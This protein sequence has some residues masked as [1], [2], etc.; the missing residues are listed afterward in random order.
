MLESVLCATR[1]EE[2]KRR[3]ELSVF[4]HIGEEYDQPGSILEDN[5]EHGL[6]R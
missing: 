2:K 4:V 1:E 5:P 3:R 6:I